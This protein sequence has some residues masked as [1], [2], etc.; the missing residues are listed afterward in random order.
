MRPCFHH[1]LRQASN[2]RVLALEF[3]SQSVDHTGIDV[4]ERGDLEGRTAE[5]VLCSHVLARWYE[6]DKSAG[7]GASF[8]S[9]SQLDDF[10]GCGVPRLGGLE[11]YEADGG[12]RLDQLR[13]T[14]ARSVG[15]L[16]RQIGNLDAVPR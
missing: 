13:G 10:R 5:T 11:G 14:T 6:N 3:A 2:F 8:G 16:E 1:L 15:E 9:I 7:R 12:W 4:G